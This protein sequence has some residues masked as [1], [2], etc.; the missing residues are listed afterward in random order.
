MSGFSSS[1]SGGKSHARYVISLCWRIAGRCRP[2]TREVLV[3][4][5]V[6]EVELHLGAIVLP[7]WCRQVRQG[8]IG[9]ELL[10]LLLC[11]SQDSMYFPQEG[12]QFLLLG[13]QV[14]INN[15]T[16][17]CRPVPGL[18]LARKRRVETPRLI[19]ESLPTERYGDRA[20]HVKVHGQ[21]DV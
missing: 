7:L 17:S 6:P 2:S 10:I 20:A 9:K 1:S 14:A 8:W 4:Q 15:N 11:P 19:P 12:E 18:P 3:L 16:G 21:V 13:V 5:L